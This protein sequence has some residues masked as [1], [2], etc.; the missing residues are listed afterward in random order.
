MCRQKKLSARACLCVL[1][2]CKNPDRQ[3]KQFVCAFIYV[4][5]LYTDS[6][7]MYV[8]FS[9]IDCKE[10]GAVFTLNINFMVIFAEY[11]VTVCDVPSALLC[12]LSVGGGRKRHRAS[13]G[14]WG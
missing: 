10:L 1:C 8:S 13:G 6:V 2:V 11:C 12:F 7:C 5:I 14:N 3:K 4:C 9:A